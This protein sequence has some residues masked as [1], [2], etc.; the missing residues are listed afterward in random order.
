MDVNRDPLA[1]FQ[2]GQTQGSSGLEVTYLAYL[3]SQ[4]IMNSVWVHR[5]LANKASLLL[6]TKLYHSNGKVL[7]AT[8]EVGVNSSLTGFKLLV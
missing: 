2:A 8:G 6:F 3:H 7:T 1:P 4:R 5:V